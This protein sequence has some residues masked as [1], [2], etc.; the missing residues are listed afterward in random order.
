[1]AG[2]E[3][4]SLVRKLLEPVLQTFW[5]FLKKLSIMFTIRTSDSTPRDLP[6]RNENICPY[7]DLY[8]NI[9]SSISHHSQGLEII[10]MSTGKWRDKQRHRIF[11][12]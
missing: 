2:W 3:D 6:K 4:E 11:S 5:P 7:K 10:R 1:M 9:H 12:T 8:M